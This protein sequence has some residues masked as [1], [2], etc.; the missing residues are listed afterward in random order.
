M[1][2]LSCWLILINIITL[3]ACQSVTRQPVISGEAVPSSDGF[4]RAL[5]PREFDFPTDDGPHPDFQTE[6][7]YFTGNLADS[8]GRRFGYQ[9]TF[10]RRALMPSVEVLE[11]SSPWAVNQ[12]YMAHFALTDVSAKDYHYYERFERGSADLAGAAGLPAFEVWLHDWSVIQTGEGTYQ[13]HSAQGEDSLDLVLDDRQGR[14][15]QGQAGF[16]PKGPGEGNASFYI[17][18]PR[19]ESEGSLVF[20]GEGF[21]VT[22]WSWMDH[23][24]STSALT[25]EQ[26]GW[27]WFAL[28]LSDGS[29]L[30]VYTIRRQDGELDPFSSG[31]YIAPDGKVQA[32]TAD[33]FEIEI[34]DTWRSPHSGGVY[35]AGW[36]LRVPLADLNLIVSPYVSDQELN[37]SFTYWEGAVAVTG[38]RAGSKLTGNGYVELTGYAHSMQ[39]QF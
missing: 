17:S 18:H 24:F 19:L 7:W 22:G 27:D 39:G 25:D 28:H 31:T 36:V 21:T 5:G 8:T 2:K 20:G 12:I 15:L 14:V 29:E 13:L 38:N 6:W 9:L 11:R 4:S 23:E 1:N 37:A 16:S 32:L 26:I 10:F 30:M 34:N 3:S 35:P 33:D